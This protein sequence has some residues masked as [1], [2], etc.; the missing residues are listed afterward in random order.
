MPSMVRTSWERDIP[1]KVSEWRK[2]FCIKSASDSK[3]Q[4]MTV[5]AFE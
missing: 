5:V 3:V 2:T 1:S 4:L